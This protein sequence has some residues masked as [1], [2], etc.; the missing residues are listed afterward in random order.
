MKS[1]GPLA[2]TTFE[3]FSSF[4][5]VEGVEGEFLC[6]SL[7]WNS[8]MA[9]PYLYG[10][11]HARAAL[12]LLCTAERPC[13][14]LTRLCT[15]GGLNTAFENRAVCYCRVSTEEQA[16]AGVS[17]EV[18]QDR[19]RAY[20]AAAGLEVVKLV[21]EPGVSGSRTFA[22][23]PGGQELLD[24]VT[25]GQV[26]AIVALK[27]DRLFRDASDALLQTRTWDRAGIALHLLDMGGQAIN[28]HSA[29][30][31]MMLTMMA[32]FAELERNLIAERTSA[33][34]LHKKLNRRVYG[35]TPYGFERVGDALVPHSGQQAVI[36]QMRECREEGWSYRE[37]A[38]VLNEAGVQTK[39][40]GQRWHPTTVRKVLLN[41]LHAGL[42]KA[43]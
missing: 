34:L 25:N 9:P 35:S 38:A 18:Q 2:T 31:R 19:M 12:R 13:T 40:G 3:S 1:G 14:V 7:E 21:L 24:L 32:A 41:D 15:E 33:A 43:A 11:F 10:M 23:R 27:L 16:R 36:R 28:T 37:I 22:N 5:Y 6:I 17:L 4:L 39:A 8:P 20:C 29:L 26:Q 42:P 30:G